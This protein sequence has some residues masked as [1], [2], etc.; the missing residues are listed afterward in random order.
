MKP[1]LLAFVLLA[2]TACQTA[3]EA[4][5]PFFADSWGTPYEVPP[6]DR[7]TID[8]YVPAFEEGMRRE[9]LEID[10]IATS[11]EPATFQN[12]ILA[13][14]NSGE[15]L[16]RVQRVFSNVTSADLNPELQA[17]AEQMMPR[18]AAHRDEIMLDEKLFERVKAIYDD[19]Q[20]LSPMQQRLTEKVY[21]S[22]VRSGALLDTQQKSELKA[23]NE[24]LST[25]TLTFGNNLLKDNQTF[26][27]LIDNEDDLAG[28]PEDIRA[29]AKTDEGKWAFTLSKPSLIPF[30]TYSSRRELRQQLYEGYLNRC[31]VDSTDNKQII[32]DLVRLRTEKAHLLGFDSHADL[33]LDIQMA[34]TPANVYGLLDALWKPSLEGAKKE[35]VQ[36]Q[37]L[38]KADGI[39]DFQSW[40]WWYYAERVRKQ[41]YDLDEE[42]L[43]PYFSLENVKKGIFM[44]SNRL[45]GIT[46]QPLAVSVYNPEVEVY[47]V[48]DRD[49]THLAVLYMDFFPRPG[50]KGGGAWCSS[51]RGQSYQDT[52]KITPLV[53]ICCNFTRPVGD[54]PALLTLDETETFFHEFGHALHSF[55]RDVPYK[56]LAG[57]ERDFVELP[58]QIME[59]WAF[60][61]AMLRQYALH[62]ATGAVIPD[63]LIAKIR[64]S[65]Y[66]NQGFTLTE[67]LA[68]SISDM[69]IH[70]QPLYEPLDVNAFEVQVLN[71]K[72]G[73]IPQIAPRY[74]YPYFAHIF[75]GG[76]SAGYYSYIWAEVLDKD[77]YEAFVES[78]DIFSPEV[79]AKFRTEILS[80]GGMADGM[81]LYRNF[82]GQEP[83]REPLLIGRGLMERPAQNDS[84]Q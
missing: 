61:P 48:L 52:L 62:Y 23:I 76:Y 55:F 57:T 21:K 28:L 38:A 11:A 12:T 5:N 56:G 32:N 44:L 26:Q 18:L 60:E 83:S 58:S 34:K 50:A 68:A 65:A 1:L 59:N 29:A 16:S 36:M 49:N 39:D 27:L 81:T 74:R 8:H 77:A 37:E 53:T 69:E 80:K 64:N 19:M 82:R 24:Q 14:D 41:Q 47:E 51:L 79:A 73:L 35:L 6:F 7:I 13:F 70:S 84:I 45:W 66:F 40:D 17:I 33:T 46:F 31:Q 3:P 25:L 2:M 15:M 9:R 4:E 22:F 43:R 10:S 71:R 72:R 30:I 67:L 78:G 54:K 75:D 20:P 42:M 63:A